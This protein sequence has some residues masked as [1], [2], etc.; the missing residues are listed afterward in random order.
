M[1]KISKKISQKIKKIKVLLTDVDGVLT[2]GGMYYTDSGLTMKK[3]NVKD[4][5]GSYILRAAGIKVGIVSSDKSEI[6]KVR[7]ERLNLDFIYIGA[8]DK[9]N[10]LNEI[11][12]QNN[13][14]YEE[15]AFIGDDINDKEILSTVGFSVSPKDALPEIK[16]IVDYISDKKGGKGVFREV[17]EMILKYRK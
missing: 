10:I 14:S 7:G 8:L 12:S 9:K 4:G 17:A 5:M 16:K 11:C 13:F 2:D 1:Q 3:F 15:I 6:A